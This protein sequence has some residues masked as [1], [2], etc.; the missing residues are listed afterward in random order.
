[1]AEEEGGRGDC[2]D[3]PGCLMCVVEYEPRSDRTPRIQTQE[4]RPQTENPKPRVEKS[5]PAKTAL[6]FP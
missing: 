2:F 5:E 1:M 3:E 6:A 4:P